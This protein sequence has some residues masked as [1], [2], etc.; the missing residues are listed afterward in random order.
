MTNYAGKLPYGQNMAGAIDYRA[1]V[2]FEQIG[3]ELPCTVK[4]ISDD[5][6]FVSVEFSIRE[7]PFQFPIITIPILQSQY[8][9]LP[10]QVGDVGVTRFADV[11]TLHICGK[12][13]GVAGFGN[14]GNLN[15]VLAFQPIVNI[16]FAQTPDKNV[17]WCYGPDGVILQD[18]AGN[19]KVTI[20]SD[21]VKLESGSSYITINKNGE[22]DIQGSSVKIMGKDFISHHH[23]GVQT[24]GSNTGGVT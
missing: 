14:A 8:I 20:N 18:Q 15:A 6:L 17:L 12:L 1:G 13:P 11:S 24:G 3:W 22:I 2:Q 16:N 7:A 21:L 23:G 9:R 10:I 19:S 4:A 5:G